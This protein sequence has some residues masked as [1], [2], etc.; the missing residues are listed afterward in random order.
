ML[1][2]NVVG[3]TVNIFDYVLIPHI[4]LNGLFKICDKLRSICVKI[5]VVFIINHFFFIKYTM[6]SAK[7]IFLV[8]F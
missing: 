1:I 7:S 4:T 2:E 5:V 3:I 8:F 6:C